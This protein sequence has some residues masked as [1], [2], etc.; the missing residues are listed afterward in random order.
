MK[1]FSPVIPGEKFEEI[2]IARDQPEYM[3]LPV[4]P[5]QDGVILSRWLMDATE[6][7][8]VAVTG[9]LY[10]CLLTFGR[11]M[12]VVKFQV[13][14]PVAE[15]SDNSTESSIEKTLY[16]GADLPVFHKTVE[17]IWLVLKLTDNDRATLSKKG[18]FYFF[19]HTEGRP[20]TPSMVQV[21]TPIGQ[22]IDFIVGLRA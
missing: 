19:M 17:C 16:V 12:P 10:I 20:I 11:E 4:I 8:V 9:V 3:P 5:F 7:R 15:S 14:S 22:D 2:I 1:P 6:K 13:D 21:E 18:D